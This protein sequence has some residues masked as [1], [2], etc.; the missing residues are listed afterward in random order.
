MNAAYQMR[1]P[2]M[3]PALS[4]LLTDR[5]STVG[6]RNAAHLLGFFGSKAKGVTPQLIEALEDVNLRENAI[7]ALGAIGPDARSAIPALLELLDQAVRALSAEAP[8]RASKK[9]SGKEIAIERFLI[10]GLLTALQ[11]IDPGN[12]ELVG[13][14]PVVPSGFAPVTDDMLRSWRQANEALR[15]KY[16]K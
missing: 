2:D 14:A 1:D 3:I 7:H 16:G 11:N 9:T 10:N 13:E 12:E 15:K 6:R 8:P 4:A 5:T